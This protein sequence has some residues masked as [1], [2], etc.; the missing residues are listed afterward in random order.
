MWPISTALP[1]FLCRRQAATDPSQITF[2]IL[3]LGT[4]FRFTDAAPCYRPRL[5]HL[6]SGIFRELY[7]GPDDLLKIKMGIG[8]HR[9]KPS[10][11]RLLLVVKARG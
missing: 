6:G 8:E 9:C 3:P 4:W 2:G 7:F 5:A 10:R 1:W 11:L